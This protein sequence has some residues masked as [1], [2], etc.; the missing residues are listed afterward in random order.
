LHRRGGQLI[1]EALLHAFQHQVADIIATVAAYAKMRL[2]AMQAAQRNAGRFN[3]HELMANL[4]I[5]LV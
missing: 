1:T 5:S 4:Q 3:P 2:A